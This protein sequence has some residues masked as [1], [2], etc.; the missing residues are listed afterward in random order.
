VAFPFGGLPQ[1]NTYLEW[2]RL[3]QGCAYKSGFMKVDGKMETFVLVENPANG[4][5]AYVFAP[6]N[7][8]MTPSAVSALDRRL[9]LDSPYPKLTVY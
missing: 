4:K 2:A 9:G 3:E 8:Y 7:E 5:H 1:V 6:I